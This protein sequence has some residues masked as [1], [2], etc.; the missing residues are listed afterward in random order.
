MA[1]VALIERD[2]F[3]PYLFSGVPKV[4]PHPSLLRAS[5]PHG[6]PLTDRAL[7]EGL[8]LRDGPAM[9]EGDGEGRRIYWRDWPAKF[10]YVVWQH[11]GAP[12]LAF[13]ELEPVATGRST[14]NWNCGM[15]L[16]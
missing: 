7:A 8:R 6:H 11:F 1:M 5:T 3:V 12:A 9:P 14:S 16:P 15:R 4:R 10:G 2:V 13:P